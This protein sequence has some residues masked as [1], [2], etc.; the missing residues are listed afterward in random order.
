M[1]I[2]GFPAPEMERL[3]GCLARLMPHVDRD[4]VAITGGVAIQLGLAAIGQ[5]GSR[6][7]IADLDLVSKQVDSVAESVTGALLVSHYHVPQP[8][9]PK[10]MIQLV[11]PT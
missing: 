8:G 1:A 7:T 2:L 5:R 11:D 4:D 9:V 10:F 3:S 6:A